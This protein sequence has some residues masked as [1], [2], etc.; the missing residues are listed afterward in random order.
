[1]N[2]LPTISDIFNYKAPKTH[3]LAALQKTDF[4]IVNL[5]LSTS[6]LH[7]NICLNPY[8]NS[9]SININDTP[10][11]K[12]I[13]NKIYTLG[14]NNINKI[15]INTSMT[16]LGECSVNS[17]QVV[18]TATF[19]SNVTFNN[20]IICK[21]LQ[22]SF[23][24]TPY[25]QNL[26]IFGKIINLGDENTIVNIIGTTNFI[27][28]TNITTTNKLL[29]LNFDNQNLPIDQGQNSGIQ[30][31]TNSGN[32]ADYG[33]IMTN[34]DATRFVIKAPMQTPAFISTLDY[35]NNLN[36]SGN[37]LLNKNVTTMGNVYINE[38]LYINKN[39][40]TAGN[41]NVFKSIYTSNL[42]ILGN[43]SFTSTLYGSSIYISNTAYLNN[44][45]I[46]SNLT[47]LAKSN[48]YDVITMQSLL[49][50]NK[51]ILNTISTTSN[52]NISGNVNICNNLLTNNNLY[53]TG[54]ANIYNNVF[55]SG[56]TQING[57]LF[58][59]L[60]SSSI[61]TTENFVV[62]SDLY[63][64]KYTNNFLIFQI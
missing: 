63:F 30:I 8:D 44:L 49:N 59:R 60:I 45:Y 7:S 17:I 48:F 31:A 20:D 38:N 26:N 47:I 52:I 18:N 39:F 22:T 28:S 50:A 23:I 36:I 56:N 1:M 29:A 64:N 37:T 51:L 25:N 12:F 2:S 61:L 19:M 5:I 41:L 62:N 55:I 42:N 57:H 21:K 43:A 27:H 35:Q 58:S 16:I 33:F 53:I 9:L 32:A 46:N 6:T 24:N 10:L 40:T 15:L 4:S 11:L 14:D 13:D 54:I 34:D 3:T